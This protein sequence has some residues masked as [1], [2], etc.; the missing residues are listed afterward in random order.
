MKNNGVYNVLSRFGENPK[1]PPPPS[2]P[3]NNR[4]SRR[5]K[6]GEQVGVSV[7]VTLTFLH[8]AHIAYF[9]GAGQRLCHSNAGPE[10]S[11]KLFAPTW[12]MWT[13]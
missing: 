12:T 11:F 3:A 2:S 8:V 9:A 4:G 6:G 10:Y 7:K 5:A 13:F 1:Q